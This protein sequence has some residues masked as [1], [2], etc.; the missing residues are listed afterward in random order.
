[1]LCDR[2]GTKVPLATGTVNRL[3][4]RGFMNFSLDWQGVGR[5]SLEK[6]F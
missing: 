6:V 3:Q 2:P 1:M 5:H 4:Q